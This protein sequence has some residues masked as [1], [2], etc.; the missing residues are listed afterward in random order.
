VIGQSSLQFFVDIRDVH[1]EFFGFFF[2]FLVVALFFL[3]FFFFFLFSFRS[4][5]VG[6]EASCWKRALLWVLWLV[7]CRRR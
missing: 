7:V 2:E 3:F 5:R 6:G 1:I 4:I